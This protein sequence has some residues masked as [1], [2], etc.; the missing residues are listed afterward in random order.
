MGYNEKTRRRAAEILSERRL[1]AETAA[2]QRRER[3]FREIP[4]AE[5]YDKKLSA[6]GI[7]AVRAL[8]KG[9]DV[10]SELTKLKTESLSVQREYEQL[11]DRHG[12]T[13]SDLEPDYFCEKCGD[14]GY[15]ESGNKTVMCD[16]L[17]TA[18]T[19]AACEEL[20]RNSPLTLSTFEDFDLKYYSMDID[21]RYPRSPYEQ[22][23]KILRYCKKYADNFSLGSG[24]IFMRGKTGL[25]K[26]HLSLAIANEVIKKGYGVIY[27]PAPKIVATLEKEQFARDKSASDVSMFTDCDLLIVDDLGTEF[28]TQ[29]SKSAIYNLFNERLLSGKPVIINTNCEL[30]E[31]EELYSQR[32]ISRIMGEATRLDFFG[33]DVRIIKK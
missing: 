23:S 10:E 1:S 2:E 4:E 12:Y 33:T 32:F 16:C 20:N 13:L 14:T 3:V 15:F 18:L 9:G 26:T 31:L 7:S 6:C 21:D 11:L 8:I 17:K 24:N 25:G 5:Q 28:S 30:T 27:A 19:E 29:F 22:M